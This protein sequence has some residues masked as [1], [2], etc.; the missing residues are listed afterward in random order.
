MVIGIRQSIQGDELVIKEGGHKR[1]WART[2]D[3]NRI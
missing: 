2:I 3:S 1:D